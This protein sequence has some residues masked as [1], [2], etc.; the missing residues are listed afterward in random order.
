MI[1]DRAMAIILAVLTFIFG[2][3][4]IIGVIFYLAGL[5][6]SSISQNQLYVFFAILLSAILASMVY[7]RGSKQKASDAAEFLN[8]RLGLEIRKEEISGLLRMLDRFPPFLVN[9]YISKDINAVKEFKD[10]IKERTAQL[11]DDD[12]SKIRKILEIPVSDLQDLLNELYLIT[13]LEQL[14]ILA[15]QGAMPFIE[16]NLEELKKILFN[17]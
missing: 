4:I 6:L 5:P 15:E 13:N 17:E 11:A 16:L 12:L 9:S 7:G 10:P 2:S 14:K 3:I 1:K 8:E